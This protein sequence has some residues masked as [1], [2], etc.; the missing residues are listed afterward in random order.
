LIREGDASDLSLVN[1][2]KLFVHSVRFGHHD[3][4]ALFAAMRHYENAN[5]PSA[6]ADDDS[7]QKSW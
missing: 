5:R 4:A 6:G 1:D 7:G 3:A 2:L